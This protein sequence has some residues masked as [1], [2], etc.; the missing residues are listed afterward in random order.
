MLRALGRALVAL[1]CALAV[2]GAAAPVL[3][4][5]L[6]PFETASARRA[7][8]CAKSDVA[9]LEEPARDCCRAAQLGMLDPTSATGASPDVPPAA[10][11]TLPASLIAALALP[12]AAT[13]PFR[14]TVERPPDRSPP[15]DTTVL[16]L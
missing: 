2:T 13:D 15:T 9:Q 5:C 3:D 7:A 4:G 8:C 16:L 6:S 1:A 11:V 14:P 10:V 12:T